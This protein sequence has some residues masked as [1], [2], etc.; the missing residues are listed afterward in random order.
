MSKPLPTRPDLDQLKKQAK[1]L[2][3]SLKT[4]EAAAL[5]RFQ[6]HHPRGRDA[7]SAR[8]AAPSLSLADAQLVLAREYGFPSWP[9]LAQ[10]IDAVLRASAD[11]LTLLHQAFDDDD[12][13]QLRQLLERH[14][15]FKA[16]IDE[17]VGAFAAPA[18]TQVR[19]RAMLDVLLDAGA[20]INAKSRWWAGGFGLLHGAEP[21]LAAYAIERGAMLDVHA[22]AR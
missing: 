19:S 18:V 22:A 3:R 16:R 12:A 9:A 15:E 11:P 5:R 7:A 17:P 6:E 4:G 21:G 14:P 10:H 2:Y 8:R 20:D 13:P 1:E